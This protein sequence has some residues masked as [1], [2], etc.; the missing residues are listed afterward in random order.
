VRASGLESC[1]RSLT[2][3]GDLDNNRIHTSEEDRK[4]RTKIHKLTGEILKKFHYRGKSTQREANTRGEPPNI[5]QHKHKEATRVKH[6][7]ILECLDE[8]EI[9]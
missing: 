7:S 2:K 8:C 3:R 1:P 9:V 5:K 4:K 6:H